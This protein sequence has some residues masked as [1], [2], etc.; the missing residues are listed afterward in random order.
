M[1]EIS[2]KNTYKQHLLKKNKSGNPDLIFPPGNHQLEMS[3]SCLSDRTL[4]SSSPWTHRVDK[5][6]TQWQFCFPYSFAMAV[7]MVEVRGNGNIFVY[8]GL[9]KLEKQNHI[10][11]KTFSFHLQI[12]HLDCIQLSRHLT[13]QVVLS[14][15][16]PSSHLRSAQTLFVDRWVVEC[17][18]R[19]M[20]Y[21]LR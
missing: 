16:A 9:S 4:S 5:A 3:S 20:G 12:L 18:H 7:L 15:P 10:S 6:E 11:R 21:H 8:M 19:E 13:V 14:F 17:V 2:C 1:Y